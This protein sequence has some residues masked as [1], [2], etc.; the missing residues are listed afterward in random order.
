MFK[1]TTVARAAW[2]SCSLFRCVGFKTL[3][4]KLMEWYQL[5][6]GFV[7]QWLDVSRSSE[8]MWLCCLKARSLFEVM[9]FPK[10]YCQ[11]WASTATPWDK[12]LDQA[13]ARNSVCQ[14]RGCDT[15]FMSVVGRIGCGS[16]T[17]QSFVGKIPLENILGKFDL[18][19]CHWTASVCC[20]LA[21]E[22]LI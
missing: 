3:S 22:F 20:H 14:T 5:L 4:T 15:V 13:G 11:V 7:W 1:V 12:L 16:S 2:S 21:A 10:C 18:A 17:S 9:V 8:G 19:W 6:F